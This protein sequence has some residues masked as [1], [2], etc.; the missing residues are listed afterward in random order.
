MT[1]T[2]VVNDNNFSSEELELMRYLAA[3]RQLSLVVEIALKDI[4]KNDKYPVVIQAKEQL[5][6][7]RINIQKTVAGL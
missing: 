6:A 5:E 1:K 2:L 7:N 3:R 4:F